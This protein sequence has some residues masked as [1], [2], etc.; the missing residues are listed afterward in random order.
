VESPVPVVAA[1]GHETD[2]TIAELVADERCATPTQAAM[3]LAPDGDALNEQLGSLAARLSSMMRRE[4]RHQSLQVEALARHRLFLAPA[5]IS[6]RAHQRLEQSVRLL[7]NVF[8]SRRQHAVSGLERLSARL[9]SHRPAS[10]YARRHNALFRAQTGLVASMRGAVARVNLAE[11]M[12]LLTVA[13]DQ[14]VERRLMTLD[15]HERAIQL[16]GPAA[17][18][19]RGYTCTLKPDGTVVRSVADVGPGDHIQTLVADGSFGSVVGEEA[20]GGPVLPREAIQREAAVSPPKRTRRRP[21]SGRDQM[22]LFG[23]GV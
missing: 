16:V 3:R 21:P 1:I 23:G 9:E 15:S 2:I 14:A 19:K 13:W 11:K 4:M 8:R 12:R 22:D 17:V 18:L 7:G 20:P 6:M 5:A 10:L